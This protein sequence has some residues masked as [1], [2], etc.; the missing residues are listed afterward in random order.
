MTPNV[1]PKTA[2]WRS[3]R[4]ADH[5]IVS[6][7][8]GRSTALRWFVQNL[9]GRVDQPH[10][11]ADAIITTTPG[12]TL[13]MRFADCVPIVIYDPIQRAI[14]LVHAGWQGTVEKI[15]QI[16]VQ[17]MHDSCRSKPDD[18]IVGIGPSI[19]PH[20]YP[21]GND[22]VE[23]VKSAFGPDADRVLY[24]S[25]EIEGEP[26]VKFDLWK[27]N[28]LILED[29]GVKNIEVAGICTACHLDDWYSH[30]AEKGRTGRFGAL[31]GL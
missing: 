23:R 28:Q 17:M 13:F 8:S 18:L 5:W 27:A 6:M 15:A 24:P 11:K 1:S 21:V 26:K 9:L 12:V 2:V 25:S 29:I 14:G 22:V 19:G 4:S 7:M 16:A 30:R 3:M 31:I 20:H 10:I